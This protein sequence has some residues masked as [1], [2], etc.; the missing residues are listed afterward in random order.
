MSDFFKKL[1]VLVKASLRDV[2]GDERTPSSAPISS[3][4]LGKDVDREIDSLR[5]RIN[6][7]LDFEDEL[8]QRLSSLQSQIASLD[9][10]ADD[11]VAQGNDDTARRKVE[12]MQRAQQRFTMTEADLRDH[13]TVTQELILRVNQLEAAVADARRAKMEST[14]EQSASPAPSSAAQSPGQMV[15]DVLRDMREKINEMNDLLQSKDEV[16]A[17]T[18][19]PVDDGVV[20]DDLAARRDRL[21]KK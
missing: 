9:Q 21:S 16:Q 13:Q 1:N 19:E 5:Q 12:E 2:I 7:A 3:D 18:Q 6:Q 4:R 11:A 10:Q 15:S 8:Q 17:Q 14:P 20:D